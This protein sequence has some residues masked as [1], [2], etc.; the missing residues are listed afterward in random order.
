MIAFPKHNYFKDKAKIIVVVSVNTTFDTIVD[1][2]LMNI[3]KPL[4]S[5]NTMHGQ[6]IKEMQKRKVDIEEID[7]TIQENLRLQDIR[8]IKKLERSQKERGKLEC[9]EKGTVA[10]YEYNDTVF[11]LLALSEFDENNKAQNTKKELIKTI[12]RLIEYY[13]NHGQGYELYIPLLGT[14]RSRTDI[15]P[16]EALQIIVSTFKIYKSAVQGNVNIIVYKKQR[17]K[18]S[19]DI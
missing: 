6:W 8:P 5:V 15:S 4:V 3:K 11:Y 16:E 9:F 14:G 18:V 13:D 10:V 12:E 17:D 19:L 1:E 2:D 7:R